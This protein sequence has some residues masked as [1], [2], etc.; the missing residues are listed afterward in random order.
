MH[1]TRPV[2]QSSQPPLNRKS[3]LT[4]CRAP[5]LA[6]GLIVSLAVLGAAQNPEIHWSFPK[7]GMQ[8]IE[9]DGKTVY[10]L[11]ATVTGMMSSLGGSQL[12]IITLP[13]DVVAKAD[14]AH[15]DDPASLPDVNKYIAGLG[16]GYAVETPE[17][18]T[19]SSLGTREIDGVRYY[20]F[21]TA[22]GASVAAAVSD[23]RTFIF[24]T[25]TPPGD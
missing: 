23:D 25:A 21:S 11:T 5:F 15:A 18:F 20:L 1:K 12:M 24:V 7:P 6:A 19:A 2:N 8:T 9:S 17:G 4:K 16:V 10:Q 22:T 13:A 3:R 14:K